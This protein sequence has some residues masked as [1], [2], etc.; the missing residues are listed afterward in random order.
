MTHPPDFGRVP[1]TNEKFDVRLFSSDYAQ[2]RYVIDTLQLFSKFH[3]YCYLLCARSVNYVFNDR[4]PCRGGMHTEGVS[5]SMGTFFE[6][7]FQQCRDEAMR[8]KFLE[9]LLIYM[10]KGTIVCSGEVVDGE[11]F[12]DALDDDAEE[13]KK[14]ETPPAADAPSSNTKCA[15]A[16]IENVRSI[17]SDVKR[18]ISKLARHAR[19]ESARSQFNNFAGKITEI[20]REPT[21]IGNGT[22]RTVEQVVGEKEELEKANREA[23]SGPLASMVCAANGLKQTEISISR[24]NYYQLEFMLQYWKKGTL[25]QKIESIIKEKALDRFQKCPT[26][27]ETSVEASKWNPRW[28]P[29]TKN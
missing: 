28:E 7:C 11:E 15:V 1:D 9:S 18:T 26:L 14:T 6:S 8:Q 10:D 16:K 29:P 17:D 22:T 20:K 3:W 2:W 4:I 24:L 21:Y 19:D 27:S 13:C 12:F 25:W 5:S 23:C